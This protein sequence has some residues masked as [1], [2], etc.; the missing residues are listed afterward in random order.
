MYPIHISGPSKI[1]TFTTYMPK[2]HKR[3]RLL[4]LRVAYVQQRNGKI[5]P[6]ANPKLVTCKTFIPE[7]TQNKSCASTDYEFETHEQTME[8]VCAWLERT[9]Q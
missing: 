8:R 9:G 2:S 5:H 4:I 7:V 6:P 1:N 3:Q